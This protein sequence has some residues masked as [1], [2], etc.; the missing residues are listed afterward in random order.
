[1]NCPS[2]KFE[3][4]DCGSFNIRITFNN[5]KVVNIPGTPSLYKF[6]LGNQA[7]AMFELIPHGEECP[8]FIKP[9]VSNLPLHFLPPAWT[10]LYGNHTW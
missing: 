5:G 9:F 2:D 8:D 7:T 6:G 4:T 1:M 3:C 10:N